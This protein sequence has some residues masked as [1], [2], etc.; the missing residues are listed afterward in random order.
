MPV[1][2]DIELTQNCSA[3]ESHTSSGKQ[4]IYTI[5]S[6]RSV[7]GAYRFAIGSHEAENGRW[8]KFGFATT[9]FHN[10]RSGSCAARG[11]AI[12]YRNDI[13]VATRV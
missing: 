1:Q 5:M 12:R 9:H 10:H 2:I 3:E 8:A 6:Q 7:E 13:M 4:A 11:T